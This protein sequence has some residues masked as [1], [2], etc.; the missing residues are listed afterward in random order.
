MQLF[1][2]GLRWSAAHPYPYTPHHLFEHFIK[3]WAHK[4]IM[5]LAVRVL[6]A[7]RDTRED[8]HRDPGTEV[9]AELWETARPWS[10][11]QLRAPVSILQKLLGESDRRPGLFMRVDEDTNQDTGEPLLN[12]GESVHSSVRVRLA[13]GGLAMDDRETWACRPL[14]ALWRLERGEFR[15][16]E[17]AGTSAEEDPPLEP[18]VGEPEDRLYPVQSGDCNWRWAYKKEVEYGGDP[19]KQ[20][21]QA[22]VMPEEPLVGYW[23]RLLLAMTAGKPDVWRYAQEEGHTPR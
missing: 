14:T 12:T 17:A 23:E 6:G 7:K 21:P 19:E 10:L 20:V 1:T 18:R 13:C 16:V 22:T 5:P 4:H 9:I 3:T 2:D 8:E 15:G 11:G